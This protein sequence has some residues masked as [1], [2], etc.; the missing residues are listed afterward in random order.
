MIGIVVSQADIASEQIGDQLRAQGDW[1]EHTDPDRAPA[2]G[3]GT[4]YRHAHFELRTFEDWHLELADMAQAFDAPTALLVASRHSGETGPLLTAHHPGNFGA[5]EYGG[6]PRSLGIAAPA[7]TAAVLAELH[8]TAPTDYDVGIECTH[9][10]P[11][12]VPV[13][14]VF[15]ELGSDKAQWTD[16]AGAKALAEGILGVPEIDAPQGSR[17]IVGIG[18]GHYAPRFYRVLTETDWTIGHIAADWSLDAMD[19]IDTDVLTAMFERSN[20]TRVLFDG[21]YPAVREAVEEAGYTPVSETWLRETSGVPLSVVE[22]LEDALRPV[23]EGLR[24]G[25]P[26]TA[27]TTA[28]FVT[29]SLPTALMDTAVGIDQDQTITALRD[30]CL[31]FETREQ[32]TR[33]GDRAAVSLSESRH[34][35]GL[36]NPLLDTVLEI[37]SRKYDSVAVTDTA[38]Q[39]TRTGFDP[40]KAR[41]HGVPEGPKF[42]QLANG[43]PVTVD[44]T[45]VTPDMVTST[46]EDRFPLSE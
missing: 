23:D 18:G 7:L 22:T 25:K 8:R 26:A 39:T 12:E 45:E 9:H 38:V 11:T 5:A 31:A 29:I 41:Q 16:P 34:E 2:D 44:G 30:T 24:F 17:S 36:P 1:T 28:E 13:P 32:G 27:Q 19:G 33:V 20:T 3:G 43:Q 15:V 6:Q 21:E 35:S 10:G 14:V 37:L 42:G 40:A 4:Y 46:R